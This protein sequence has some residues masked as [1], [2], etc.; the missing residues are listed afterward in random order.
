MV[1][2]T[3]LS[4]TIYLSHKIVTDANRYVKIFVHNSGPYLLDAANMFLR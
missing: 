3:D 4:L 2:M 1:K